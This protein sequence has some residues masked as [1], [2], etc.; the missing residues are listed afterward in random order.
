MGMMEMGLKF[1]IDEN[2]MCSALTTVYLPEHLKVGFLQQKLRE[3]KIIIYEGKGEFKNKVFQV[4]N[5]G[6]LSLM[7]INFFLNLLKKI[8]HSF[9]FISVKKKLTKNQKFNKTNTHI[10]NPLSFH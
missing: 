6:E 4:G 10:K 9:S 7:K 2:D 3:K 1:L 8:L 5:I